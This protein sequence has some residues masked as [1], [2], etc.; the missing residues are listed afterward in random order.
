[1]ASRLSDTEVADPTRKRL[2]SGSSIVPNRIPGVAQLLVSTPGRRHTNA[3]PG[4]GKLNGSPLGVTP[5][6]TIYSKQVVF[7]YKGPAIVMFLGLAWRPKGL[8]LH[9][10]FNNGQGIVNKSGA[11]GLKVFSLAASEVYTPHELNMGI[12][13]AAVL[14]AQT[15]GGG[16]VTIGGEPVSLESNPPVWY[17]FV[18]NSKLPGGAT[19]L[20]NLTN[21][22]YMVPVEQALQPDSTFQ[23]DTD[24]VSISTPAPVGSK[25][26]TPN[27]LY[28]KL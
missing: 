22:A 15:P 27:I 11:W 28:A 16:Y 17:W 2:S 8:L 5:G 3:Q 7:Q 24:V 21:T 4:I 10:P 6:T 19:T 1:M 13:A 14:V 9:K 26:R 18:D 12:E 23:D 25:L 20:A